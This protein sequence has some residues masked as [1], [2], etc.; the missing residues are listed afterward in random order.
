LADEAEAR[1]L[2]SHAATCTWCGTVLREAA[3]DL[4]APPTDEELALAAATRLADPAQR[5][6]FAERLAASAPPVPAPKPPRLWAWGT[7]AAALAS[8]ATVAVFFWPFSAVLQTERQLARAYTEY[9][10]MQMRLPRAAYG[11]VH[12]ERD[13]TGILPINRSPDL[14]EAEARI[15]RQIDA[16]PDDPA[17]LHLQGRM[18]VLTGHEDDAIAELERAHALRPKDA[19]ILCD[20]GAA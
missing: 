19:D 3:Q 10:P 12:T 14:H 13:A 8:A 17:W 6:A 7:A 2:L 11:L 16:H 4:E 5:R 18:H 9:R 1:E 20:L 15:L